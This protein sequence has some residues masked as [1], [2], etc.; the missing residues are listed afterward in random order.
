MWG[1]RI[2][3]FDTVVVTRHR[4]GAFAPPDDKLR[5]VTQHA[6]APR[7]NRTVS[8][9]L[10][11]PPSRVMTIMIRFSDRAPFQTTTEISFKT[12]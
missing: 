10:D 1:C 4:V 9:I 7:F 11:H 3:A 6:A 8:G 5:R 12:L 2:C